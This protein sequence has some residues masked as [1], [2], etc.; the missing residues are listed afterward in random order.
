MV[1]NVLSRILN[2]IG[3]F[4]VFKFHPK[5]KKVELSHLCFADDLLIFTH[6]DMD[7]I[8]GI[9]RMLAMF[10]FIYDLKLNDCLLLV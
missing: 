3:K 10:Y 9:Q 6:G 8:M 2:E 5:C 7:S 1:M 4:G